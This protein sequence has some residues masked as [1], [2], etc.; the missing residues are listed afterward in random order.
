MTT[1][2]AFVTAVCLATALAASAQAAPHVI[3]VDGYRISIT[4]EPR[5]ERVAKRVGEI[6]TE[7]LPEL[8]ADIGF[9]AEHQGIYINK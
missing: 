3:S 2:R 5:N 8:L 1:A 9:H 4:F 6:V 7:T